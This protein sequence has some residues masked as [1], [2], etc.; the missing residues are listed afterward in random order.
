MQYT[1]CVHM[2]SFYID[3]ILHEQCCLDIYWVIVNTK[4]TIIFT[5]TGHITL[6][7]KHSFFTMNL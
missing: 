3:V 2:E 5:Y 1:L 7:V 4:C 6:T